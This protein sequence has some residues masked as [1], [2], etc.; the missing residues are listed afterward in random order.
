MLDILKIV[1]RRL[2]ERLVGAAALA[3]VAIIL[4]PEMLSGPRTPTNRPEQSTDAVKT[5]AI[6][7]QK[8]PARRDAEKPPEP[9]PLQSAP[10]QTVTQTPPPQEQ[11]AA[12]ASNAQ[13]LM[14][15][16]QVEDAPAPPPEPAP[17]A[18]DVPAARPVSAS[19]AP[20]VS[21]A[22]AVQVA[23]LGTRAAAEQLALDLKRR[24]Y[25]AFVMEYKTGGKTLFRTRVGPASERQAADD[26]LTR[27]RKDYPAA[28]LVTQP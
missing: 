8:K 5:Y 22:W 2:Q 26:L 21:G 7:L 1:E 11:S 20:D 27:I 17:I 15:A 28:A 6:D 10:S 12:P 13:A 18:K 14:E 19:K 9:D 25:P 4:I 16:A 24:G 3:A 23:S